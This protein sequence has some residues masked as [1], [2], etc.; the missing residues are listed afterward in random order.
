MCCVCVALRLY[1][2]RVVQSKMEWLDGSERETETKRSLRREY[3]ERKWLIFFFRLKTCYFVENQFWFYSSS[4]LRCFGCWC[5]LC[6]FFFII[7]EKYFTSLF[8]P[9]TSSYGLCSRAFV[10]AFVLCS[11]CVCVMCVCVVLLLILALLIW[12]PC[13]FQHCFLLFS[14]FHFISFLFFSYP[15]LSFFLFGKSTSCW[16]FYCNWDSIHDSSMKCAKV[17]QT[18]KPF[19][20][21]TLS[22]WQ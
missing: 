4:S 1:G 15:L 3:V 21:A 5:W 13:L 14:F 16:L 6:F 10:H 2:W 9:F 19:H 18:T 7:I 22:V 17:W 11:R 8:F 12:Y 20:I